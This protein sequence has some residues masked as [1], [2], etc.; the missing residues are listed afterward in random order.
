MDLAQAW[1]GGEGSA[2]G[3]RLSGER[4]CRVRH[5]HDADH[6]PPLLM[7]LLHAT[8]PP[9]LCRC[10][11]PLGLHPAPL[12][13]RSLFDPSLCLPFPPVLR[14]ANHPDAIGLYGR[15]SGRLGGAR[16]GDAGEFLAPHRLCRE[17]CRG[18]ALG[19]AVGEGT[20]ARAGANWRG[21]WRLCGCA[22][23]GGG[24]ARAE[25]SGKRSR[26]VAVVGDVSGEGQGRNGSGRV[27]RGS[28]GVVRG[29]E[30]WLGGRVE[31]AGREQGL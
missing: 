12:C 18:G 23:T 30:A 7:L 25:V 20:C 16:S 5:L 21:G 1:P 15:C 9:L 28:G 10:L 14:Q 11:P 2:C 17:W 6:A 19:P 29:A 22:V 26:A 3:R 31:P 4:L 27:G 8:V 13:S 24:G